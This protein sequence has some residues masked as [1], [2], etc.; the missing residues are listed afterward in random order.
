MH[1]GVHLCD[2]RHWKA[3]NKMGGM[4]QMA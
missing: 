1:A 2:F 4:R 3:V